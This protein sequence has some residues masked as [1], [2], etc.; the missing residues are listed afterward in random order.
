MLSSG[1]Y[2]HLV[3]SPGERFLKKRARKPA[4]RTKRGGRAAHQAMGTYVHTPGIPGICFWPQSGSFAAFFAL[5]SENSD[6]QGSTYRS[7]S[8]PLLDSRHRV[9][10]RGSGPGPLSLENTG[11]GS[12]GRREGGAGQHQH[13]GWQTRGEPRSSASS[14]PTG[15]LGRSPLREAP[16]GNSKGNA[17]SKSLR[18]HEVPYARS[19]GSTADGEAAEKGVT[20]RC[21]F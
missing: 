11:G 13:Q 19:A 14:Q 9:M 6:T 18:P 12:E 16:A 2:S 21:V 17:K 7:L 20:L 5:D 15:V 3:Y 4:Q 10:K 1:L 8:L